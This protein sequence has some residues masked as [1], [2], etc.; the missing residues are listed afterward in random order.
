M[1][2]NIGDIFID[3]SGNSYTV[4]EE[5]LSGDFIVIHSDGLSYRWTR[6]VLIREL[7]NKTLMHTRQYDD[8]LLNNEEVSNFNFCNHNWKTVDLFTSSSTY[9]TLC[10]EE[11]ND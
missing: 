5:L 4:L 9:C 7:N 1:K 2:I 3:N 10:G 11:K 8:K 6:E